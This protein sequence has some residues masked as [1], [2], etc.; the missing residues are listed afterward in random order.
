[1]RRLADSGDLRA[2][3]IGALGMIELAAMQIAERQAQDFAPG[4]IFA[5]EKV[6]RV[7]ARAAQFGPGNFIVKVSDLPPASGSIHYIMRELSAIS[8]GYSRQEPT[9]IIACL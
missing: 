6:E 4:S 8:L 9:P 1:M 5:R 2:H 7:I 3:P